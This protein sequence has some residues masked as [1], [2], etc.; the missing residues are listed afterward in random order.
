MRA[1]DIV[2]LR[3][4]DL[5]DQNCILFL[6]VMNSEI[7][8]ALRCIKAWGFEYKTVAFTWVKTERQLITSAV[9]TG[10]DVF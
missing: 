4:Q 6:W 8:L 10:L 9:A 2:D 5:A 1:D 7:P 3:V